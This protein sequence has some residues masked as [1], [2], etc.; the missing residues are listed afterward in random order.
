MIR[1][2]RKDKSLPK[3]II[4]GNKIMFKICINTK[5]GFKFLKDTHGKEVEFETYN[6]AQQEIDAAYNLGADIFGITIM[7]SPINECSLDG[8]N[9]DTN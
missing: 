9:N 6:E 5:T 3:E 2:M 8:D 7:E 4:A 1:P